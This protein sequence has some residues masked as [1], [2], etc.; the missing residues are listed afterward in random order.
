MI[1]LRIP[2]FDFL[3]ITLFL[4]RHINTKANAEKEKLK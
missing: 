1:E 3:K 2:R 4:L